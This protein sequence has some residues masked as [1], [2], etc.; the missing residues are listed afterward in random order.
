ME[1]KKQLE[2]QR[3]YCHKHKNKKLKQKEEGEKKPKTK[4]IEKTPNEL[5]TT[6][7]V[8]KVSKIFSFADYLNIM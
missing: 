8:L 5:E 7:N 3:Q 6:C 2:K 4:E 1:R